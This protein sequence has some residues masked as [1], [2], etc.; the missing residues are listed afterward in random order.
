VKLGNAGDFIL[1]LGERK[2]KEKEKK[3]PAVERETEAA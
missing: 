1:L 3:K 2:K